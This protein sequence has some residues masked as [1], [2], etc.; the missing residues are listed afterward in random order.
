[1]TAA[2]YC[3]GHFIVLDS[4]LYSITACVSSHI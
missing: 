1:M 4:F 3:R 2:I